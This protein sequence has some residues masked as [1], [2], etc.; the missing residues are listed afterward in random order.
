M[1]QNIA[2]YIGIQML[3]IFVLLIK[4]PE[5]FFKK[6]TDVYILSTNCT[7]WLHQKVVVINNFILFISV[8]T[9]PVYVKSPCGN[10]TNN[11]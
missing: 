2:R 1:E 7:T 11:L 6:K 5:Y 9:R 4:Q 8:K 10:F 3:E